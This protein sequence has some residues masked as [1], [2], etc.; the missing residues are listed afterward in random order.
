MYTRI[1]HKTREKT[2]CNGLAGNMKPTNEKSLF[3]LFQMFYQVL[4]TLSQ[5]VWLAYGF[6]FFLIVLVE[7]LDANRRSDSFPS[8][9]SDQ[10]EGFSDLTASQGSL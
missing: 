10:M 8:I 2:D 4:P 6:F 7:W 9:L 3:I 5:K 1:L